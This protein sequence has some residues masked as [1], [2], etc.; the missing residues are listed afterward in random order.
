[1]MSIYSNDNSRVGAYCNTPL[2]S[3]NKFSLIS[4]IIHAITKGQKNFDDHYYPTIL[5]CC[6]Y[7]F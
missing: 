4:H 1:M 5:D 6:E 7:I 3:I 2:L